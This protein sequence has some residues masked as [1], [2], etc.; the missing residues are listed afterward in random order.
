MLLLGFD[1]DV[2]FSSPGD[3]ALEGLG[4]GASERLSSDRAA[5]Q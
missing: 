3:G 1:V 5:I 4:E 2:S